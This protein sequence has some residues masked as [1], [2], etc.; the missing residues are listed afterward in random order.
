MSAVIEV[1]NL[2][3]RFRVPLD[4]TAHLKYRL[5]HPISTSRNRELLALK[6]VS[7][8]V[9]E[10]Q[11]LGI[12]GAN[13]S[14]KS[15]LLKILARIYRQTSGS[16]RV[17]G[18]V[19]PF[20]ELGVGFNPEL[21]G[22]E[23]VYLNGAI[24][25][26]S[27]A[28]LSRRMDAIMHF[29]DLEGFADQKL[30][31][32]SSGMQ[33]RLGFTVAIQAE[34]AILLMDEVLAV[35]DARFQ[36]KCFEVFARY[37]REGRTVVLVTHDLIGVEQH[38]DRAL[39]LERGE[40]VTEGDPIDVTTTY[41]RRA[42]VLA[43]VELE[44]GDDAP[45]RRWGTG[46]VRMRRVLLESEP[47]A[48]GGHFE[49]GSK[50]RLEIEVEGVETDSHPISVGFAL[51]RSDT[52]HMSGT[53]TLLDRLTLPALAPGERL[54]LEYATGGLPLLDGTYRLDVAVESR[55]TLVTYDWIEGAANFSVTDPRG[56][57]G[58]VDLGGRWSLL[59][60]PPAQARRR[61]S[62]SRR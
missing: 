33:V 21:T 17:R 42:G 53:N 15:T 56:R 54:V 52:T 11:F 32:Y 26:L 40:V 58:F 13:G 47:G 28:E 51:H 23:N 9:P 1:R 29:A 62:G 12:V 14:G 41:R 55:L 61:A 49:T 37:K 36:A 46:A 45:K 59:S 44:G 5:T 50:L 7:F 25:G 20:L 24:L 6:D 16:V 39:L 57:A 34:A 48:A 30:K 4:R 27:R 60:A 8:D 38:C 2:T 19:S 31:N 35:G 22:R 10:G 43:D 18:Q 3:K